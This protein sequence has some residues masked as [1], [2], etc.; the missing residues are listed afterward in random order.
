MI[1][2]TT[3]DEKELRCA[4]CQHTAKSHNL[5]GQ[6]L[7]PKSKGGLYPCTGCDCKSFG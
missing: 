3:G 1:E 5:R 2:P 4:S 6:F 7:N